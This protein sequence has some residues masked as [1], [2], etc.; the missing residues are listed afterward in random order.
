MRSA[1][2]EVIDSARSDLVLA[3]YSLLGIAHQRSADKPARP[4]LLLDPVRAAVDRGVEVRLLLRGR[5]I[6][7]ATRREAATFADAGVPIVPDR[8]NH[9]K[10]V[11]V[12]AVRGALFSANFVPHMGLFGGV[13]VGLRLDDTLALAEASRCFVHAGP[14]PTSTSYVTRPWPSWR[15]ACTRSP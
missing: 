13:E 9:A 4:E 10:G 1:I 2:R 14:R 7:D 15:Q 6:D 5:N 11:I 8:L 3:S 12:D